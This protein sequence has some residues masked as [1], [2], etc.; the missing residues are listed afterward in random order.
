MNTISSEK[1]EP[2]V[3]PLLLVL[4]AVTLGAVGQIMLKQGMGGTGVSGSIGQ[5]GRILFRAI[6]TPYVLFGL[7]LYGISALFWLK[8]LS[9]QELSYVYPMIAVSYVI[10]TVL[11][12]IFLREQISPMRWVALLVICAGVAMLALWGANKAQ[13]QESTAQVLEVESLEGKNL[14]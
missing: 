10:V 9:T 6:L 11:S 8:V 3:H 12:I 5:Q 14:P 4:I 1:K 2:L 13:A 7:M